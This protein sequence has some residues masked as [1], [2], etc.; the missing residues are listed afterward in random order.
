MEQLLNQ[1]EFANV[2]WIGMN[3]RIKGQD[4]DSVE[5]DDQVLKGKGPSQV[6]RGL[7][8]FLLVCIVA[9]LLNAGQFAGFLA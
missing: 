8:D 7:E 1:V 4:G 9:K 2:S 6:E 5:E 3:S